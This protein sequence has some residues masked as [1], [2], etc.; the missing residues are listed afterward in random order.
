M[1]VMLYGVLMTSSHNH[2]QQHQ[3]QT[4]Q[5]QQS[6]LS[7]IRL[8]LIFIASIKQGHNQNN[9]LFNFTLRSFVSLHI[10]SIGPELCDEI[11]N[12]CISNEFDL[13]VPQLK[14]PR[15]DY[16]YYECYKLGFLIKDCHCLK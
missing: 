14:R 4:Q 11:S 2:H 1:L 6:F 8:T 12:I 13:N 16:S 3:H 5:Q 9:F 15:I 10:S 7:E